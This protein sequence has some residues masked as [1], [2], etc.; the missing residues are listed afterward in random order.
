MTI[1]VSTKSPARGTPNALI[2][3]ALVFFALPALA[4]NCESLA[5]LQ[6]TNVTITKAEALT[7][8]TFVLPDNKPITGLP[9]FCRVVATI[10][11]TAD[12]DIRVELWMPQA[13]WNGRIEG[14]GNGGLAGG[15]NYSSLA[16]GVRLAYA[17]ANTDMGM[18]TPSGADASIF[19][20]HPERW[21]D[22]GYRATHEMTMLAKQLVSAYYGHGAKK[23][24]FVGCSTGGEQGLMEVQRFPDDYDGVVS[25]AAANNRTGVHVSILW[26]FAVPQRSAEAY[27]SPANI[28]MLSKAVINSCDSLDGVRDGLIADP[29]SCKFDP[30]EL[31]CKGGPQDACLTRAQVETVREIYSGPVNP[32]TGASLYPGL[33]K[34]SEMGW[35]KLAAS[36]GSA[37]S[38][39]YA[40]VF[41]WAFGL[42]I[43]TG[44]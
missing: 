44:M 42:L 43:S 30:G 37:K 13:G 1:G 39:P 21:A 26:N 5:K 7:S 31:E 40:P 6:L 22:W 2:V 8:G 35:D 18:A 34:G 16:A 29:L 28:A 27:L 36:P 25:G 3:A 23:S 32:R 11:P 15:I 41:E 9:A 12:S 14:T 4:S 17:V 33:A 19:V 10:K 38:A 24:Y 20:N